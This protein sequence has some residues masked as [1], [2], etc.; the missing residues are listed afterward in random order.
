[1]RKRAIHRIG[2]QDIVVAGHLLGDFLQPPI[3]ALLADDPE[4][5]YCLRTASRRQCGGLGVG[6]GDKKGVPKECGPRP[7]RRGREPERTLKNEGPLWLPA[8]WALKGEKI[9]MP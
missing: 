8:F 7:G 5:R 4:G 1:M 2:P 3:S 6:E 9:S